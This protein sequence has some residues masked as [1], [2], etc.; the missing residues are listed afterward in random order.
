MSSLVQSKKTKSYYLQFYRDDRSPKRKQVPLKTQSKRAAM[1]LRSHVD[2][3]YLR[4]E[5]DPWK[6]TDFVAATQPE[7]ES[8][9]VPLREA[10]P[11][12]LASRA[13]RSER[14]VLMYDQMLGLMVRSM[15]KGI[16]VHEVNRTLLRRWATAGETKAVTQHTKARH[17]SVFFRWAADEGQIT[18]TDGVS[19]LN[20]ATNLRLPSIPSKRPRW[21]RT[22]EV[23]LILDS[24]P[25]SGR[26]VAN[27]QHWLYSVV[28]TN[29]VLGLRASEVCR[30]IWR[31]IDLE[32][33]ELI[34]Y[35]TKGHAERSVPLASVVVQELR[36][37]KETQQ[38]ALQRP[39]SPTDYVF[40]TSLD[41][42]MM[43]SRYL[44]RQFKRY[45]RES[46]PE[47]RA[48][49]INFHSTRHSAASY[50]AQ[51]GKTAEF[52]REYMGHASVATTYRYVHLDKS[53]V[54]D[55]SVEVFD[56][57]FK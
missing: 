24:L 52:I 9:V 39:V 10:I 50:L 40:K 22:E 21:I 23:A 53:R 32:D 8:N 46:L 44:S 16:K 33:G 35:T 36:W 57:L 28:K 48:S 2:E 11:L 49:E 43:C 51:A 47:H 56:T 31:D 20:P 12:F 37:L 15:P 13:G 45:V 38:E 4:G 55:E 5:F 54:K 29:V 17:A 3:L 14:T 34:V 1:K 27:G 41:A 26:G 19:V 18:D 42:G 6:T 30:S 7:V 25:T